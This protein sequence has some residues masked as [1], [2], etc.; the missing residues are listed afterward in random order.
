VG[1]FLGVRMGYFS[2]KIAFGEFFIL[3]WFPLVLFGFDGV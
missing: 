1:G 3:F 2:Q